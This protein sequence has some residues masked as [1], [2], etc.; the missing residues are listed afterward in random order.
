MVLI[1]SSVWIE[2]FRTKTTTIG[3][4]V[5]DLLDTNDATLCGVVEMEILHGLRPREQKK[6][7]ELFKVL[8]YINTERQDFIEAGLLL[9]RL[10]STGITI[11]ATD[12]L[13]ATICLRHNL[14][15]FSLDKHFDYL[16]ELKRFK[17]LAG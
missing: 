1:D 9:A 3:D 8:P 2:F 14:S 13:I 10:R 4:S 7:A 16:T 12:A 6:I 15:L 11:P 17:Q 5:E